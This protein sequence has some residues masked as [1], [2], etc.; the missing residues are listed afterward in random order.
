MGIA[1]DKSIRVNEISLN[2]NTSSIIPCTPNNLY[3]IKGIIEFK[4]KI[5][6]IGKKNIKAYIITHE[7]FENILSKYQLD[8]DEYKVFNQIIFEKEDI[9]NL[10]EKEI[11]IINSVEELDL[12]E[13]DNLHF[14]IVEE[15]TMKIYFKE[16]DYY[17]K[18]IFY[19]II[20][21]DKHQIIFKDLS[22]IKI[23]KNNNNKKYNIIPPQINQLEDIKTPNNSQISKKYKDISI[24]ESINSHLL[25]NKKIKKINNLNGSSISNNRYNQK[26]KDICFIENNNNTK[27]N[28]VK[29]KNHI[30]FKDNKN[31]EEENSDIKNKSN[32]INLQNSCLSELP[33]IN[34]NQNNHKDNDNN[35]KQ[36]IIIDIQ[37]IDIKFFYNNLS[38]ILE[39]KEK[40][41]KMMNAT[42]DLNK[43]FNNYLLINKNWFNKL[44]KIFEKEEIYKN[45]KVIFDFK[46]VKDLF[47]MNSIELKDKN[48]LFE[49]R[50]EHLK[51]EK[52]FKLE[53]ET[54]K[55]L[56]IKYPKDFILIEKER[57]NKLNI[58]INNYDINKNLY[59]ILFG[60]G[61]IF[62]KNN[63]NNKIIYVCSIYEYFFSVNIVLNYENEN[64]F[65]DEIKLFIQN[66]GGLDYYIN[67]KGFNLNYNCPQRNLSQ[68]SDYLGEC[69]IVKYNKEENGKNNIQNNNTIDT[70]T[71][72]EEQSSI[73]NN[74]N[75]NPYLKVIIISF[76]K[77]EPLYKYFIENR[78]INNNGLVG[79][80]SKFMN[81]YQN[82][83]KINMNIINKIEEK[84]NEIN[85]DILKNNNFKNIIDFIL[86]KL[87]EEL[88]EKDILEINNTIKESFDED[89]ALNLFKDNY[90]S[91][92]NS[93]ISKI[94]FG[95]K[96]LIIQKIVVLIKDI[97]LM[98]VNIFILI[99]KK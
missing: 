76:L 89:N 61:Y 58:N 83:I 86:T 91:Q 24:H 14:E 90:L 21:K 6:T 67:N 29:M 31:N 66:K 15:P 87:H 54:E 51:D 72:K 59:K 46:N 78:N 88:N 17:N 7:Y 99:L 71:P 96:E 40:I 55:E 57:F 63:E 77:I 30:I 1:N 84:I 64:Y 36:N 38:K 95:I 12:K 65:N 4:N 79:L 43:E 52:L 48:K 80:L 94:F 98:Y 75:Y 74:N 27:I 49:E 25:S 11:K 33:N 5:R 93:E 60:E 50:K 73:L 68:G 22:K 41:K 45:D 70:P 8:N 47:L 56:K 2:K 81:E 35:R 92:N 69:I 53:F 18:D 23:T 16:K 34:N 3:I 10:N 20:S 42:I 32:N 19:K 26:D 85:P 39:E 62:V 28:K 13:N 37:K 9:N 44:I 82:N 97:I